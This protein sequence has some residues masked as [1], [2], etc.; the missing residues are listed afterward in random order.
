MSATRVAWFHCFSGIA[1]DMALAA[2]LDCG[3]P[4]DEL[5]ADLRTLARS[6]QGP[7]TARE[8]AVDP[9]SNPFGHSARW[10]NRRETLVPHREEAEV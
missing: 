4:L 8:M 3:A 10:R 9:V 2:L 1:G 7:R 5:K 6:T